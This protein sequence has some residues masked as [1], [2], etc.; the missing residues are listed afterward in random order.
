MLNIS[1]FTYGMSVL[2]IF[3]EGNV[4]PPSMLDIDEKVLIDQFMSGIKAIACLSLGMKNYPTIVSV[5]HS[6]VNAY[7][8]LLHVSLATDYEFEG[9]AKV[10]EE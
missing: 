6:L 9:S 3:S 7:K 10:S 2:Q 1:P 5:G 8:N 4:F